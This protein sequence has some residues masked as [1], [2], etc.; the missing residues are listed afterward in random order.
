M[1]DRSASVTRD[2]NETQIR[3]ELSIDGTGSSEI[4][5]GVGFFDHMLTH[6]AKHGMLDLKV[7][8]KGDLEVDAHHVVE[9]VGIVLGRAIAQAV[10][11]KAGIV[12]YGWAL[13]PMDE[14]LVGVALDL[15]GRSYLNFDLKL[16]PAQVGEFDTELALEFFR[17]VAA[18]AA[19]T[20][21]VWQQYGR[22]AHHII[23]AAFK[24]FGRALDEATRIDPRRAGDLPSTK[25]TL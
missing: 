16:G 23:E 4:A 12:R 1:S 6:I 3:L 13:C 8:A 24:A 19:M 2:T 25:G 10:G 9:D 5:T 17:A 14:A 20:L 21:H 22:N 11:D 15:S 7:R 18:N